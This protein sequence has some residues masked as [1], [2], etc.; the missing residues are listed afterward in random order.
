[1]DIVCPTLGLTPERVD[2][3]QI[4]KEFADKELRPLSSSW[5]RSAEIPVDTFKKFASI[6]FSGLFVE[7]DYGGTNLSR[8]DT[9]PI[10]E[11]LSTG[12]VSVTALLTIHNANA[13][14][15]NKYGNEEQRKKWLSKLVNME[16]FASFCLT[17]PG[18]ALQSLFS[19]YV[20]YC[21]LNVCYLNRK[22]FGRSIFAN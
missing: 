7:Q 15:F 13:L 4:A 10:I 5:D 18:A 20:I 11:A 17:E 9:M 3:Y 22:W 16:L 14:I 1:M 2:F 12:C 21:V 8:S 6:G 19:I